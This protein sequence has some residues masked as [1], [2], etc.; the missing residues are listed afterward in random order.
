M[1]AFDEA[2]GLGSGSVSPAG[3]VS[4]FFPVPLSLASSIR[5]HP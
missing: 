2:D 1:H 3:I 5:G 4:T